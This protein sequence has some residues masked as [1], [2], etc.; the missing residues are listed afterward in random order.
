VAS[1]INVF[2][3]KI[4]EMV[5]ANA[6]FSTLHNLVSNMDRFSFDRGGIVKFGGLVVYLWGV[7]PRL[8]PTIA[9]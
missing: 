5:R 3:A 4:C 9:G 2:V 6:P 7:I 8:D 1:Q